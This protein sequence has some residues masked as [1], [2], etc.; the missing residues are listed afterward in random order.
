EEHVVVRDAVEPAEEPDARE[1][2]DRPHALAVPRGSRAERVQAGREVRQ[3]QA[4]AREAEQDARDGEAV[5]RLLLVE[6]PRLGPEPRVARDPPERREEHPKEP[7]RGA[8]RAGDDGS[9]AGG[10][11]AQRVAPARRHS[12]ILSYCARKTSVN[13]SCDWPSFTTGARQPVGEYWIAG[14]SASGSWRS[15]KGITFWRVARYCTC[16]TSSPQ[17]A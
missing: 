4:D 12:A 15:A 3:Q 10:A 7:T 13:A 16:S 9:D 6:Q 5:E 14:R 17:R 8:R 11:G 1:V 2:A